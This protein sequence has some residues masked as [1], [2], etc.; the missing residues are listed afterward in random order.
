MTVKI[1]KHSIGPANGR[2]TINTYVGGM[3]S[4]MG[5]DLVLEAKRWQGTVDL[6]SS[7]AES[8]AE[9]SID[10]N[11]LEVAEATGGLKAL[12]DK[13][14][15]EIS[16]NL[17]KTLGSDKFPQITFRST[18]VDGALPSL[19]LRGDL[20]IK[21]STNPITVDLI[22]DEATEHTVTGTTKLQQT[23]YG[24]KPYSK[25]GAL[26]VK[27]EVEMTVVLTLPSD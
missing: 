22:V 11:S 6:G 23:D 14:R 18:S 24:I 15:K 27:D 4:K 19:V 10:S 16:D 13:D 9:A 2:L 26:K 20:T 7:P 21:G 3:G 12:T 5:H 8:S 1:G 25:L 17:Q